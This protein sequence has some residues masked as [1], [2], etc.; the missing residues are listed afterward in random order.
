M[1]R[2]I[3]PV[4]ATLKFNPTNELPFVVRVLGMQRH[5]ISASNHR[6]ELPTHSDELGLL[7]G[8]SRQRTRK[9]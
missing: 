6:R 2:N 4:D 3:K 5:L 1:R 9:R 7:F 8:K